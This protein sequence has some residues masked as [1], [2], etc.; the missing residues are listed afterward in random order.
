M[1]DF[2]GTLDHPHHW[3]DRFLR[4]YREAGIDLSRAELDAAYAHA[5][6]TAYA[7]EARLHRH[8][9]RELLHFLVAHQFD[10][11]HR[12][13]PAEVRERLLSVDQQQHRLAE[14]IAAGFAEE[15]AQGLARSRE[16]LRELSQEFK[17]GVVSNFYGN[18]EVILFEAG[19][20][21]LIQVAID[22]K[23]FGIL[24]PDQR[25]FLAALKALDLPHN[26]VAMVGDSLHKDCAPARKLGMHAVWLRAGRAAPAQAQEAQEAAALADRTVGSLEELKGLKWETAGS[27]G[28]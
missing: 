27:A 11:L 9:L 16:L 10:H 4:H 15:S 21:E 14:R 28:R 26:R 1:F 7:E 24:K 13:G 6:R 25:I 23:H 12:H 8:N 2:G 20:R 5:T 22:S 17:L 18:L 19:I 3:L